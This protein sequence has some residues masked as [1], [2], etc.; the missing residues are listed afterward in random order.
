[1]IPRVGE[2]RHLRDFTIHLLF[3]DGTGG[4]VDFSGELYGK[5]F[6]PLKDPEQFQQ[7]FVH[8]EFRTLCWPNGADFA[9]GFLYDKVRM[10]ASP[11]EKR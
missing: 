4:E 11:Q 2:A 1:M 9:P 3:S 5:M 6:E 8:A 10:P 7:F